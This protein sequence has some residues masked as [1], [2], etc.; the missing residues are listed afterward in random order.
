MGF[1]TTILWAVGRA[2]GLHVIN[3]AIDYFVPEP[4]A[5]QCKAVFKLILAIWA[6]AK[7]VQQLWNVW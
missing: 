3:Q 4:Y 7:C 5:S 2:T 1:W 6:L